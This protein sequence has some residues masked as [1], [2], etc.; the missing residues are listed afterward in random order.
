[1]SIQQMKWLMIIFEPFTRPKR[2]YTHL[3]YSHSKCGVIVIIYRNTE[4]KTN[5]LWGKNILGAIPLHWS[6]NFRYPSKQLQIYPPSVFSQVSLDLS[7]EFV[8]VEVHSLI[9]LKNQ[10]T[11]TSIWV[12]PGKHC[13]F[14]ERM[15]VC[16][17]YDYTDESSKK[18]MFSGKIFSTLTFI[19]DL[20]VPR[21]TCR[22]IVSSS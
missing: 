21:W 2:T 13:N 5:T 4:L 12:F 1:M 8:L 17:N 3:Y 20:L 19:V 18:I 10:N 22:A 16:N 7:Q 11:D 14:R 15:H 6:F 9:S